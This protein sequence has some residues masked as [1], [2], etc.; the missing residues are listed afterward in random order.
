MAIKTIHGHRHHHGWDSMRAPTAR[1]ASGDSLEFEVLEVTTGQITQNSVASDL[2]I[3]DHRLANPLTGPIA[4]DGAEPGDTLKVTVLGFEPSGW[5]WTGIIPGFGLLAD[6][7]KEP[8]LHHWRYDA[9]SMGPAAFGRIARVPLRPFPSTIGVAPAAPGPHNVML[10]R[11]TAGNINIRNLVAGATLSVPV[12]APG[13]LF[14]VGDIHAAQGDGEVCGAAIESPMKVSLRFDLVKGE[15]LTA[16]SVSTPPLPGSW[17]DR[18]GYEITTG[19]D[20]DLY[21]AARAVVSK[22]IDLLCKRYAMAATDAYMLCSVCGDLRISSAV[23]QP[24]WVVTFHFPR[25]VLS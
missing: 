15:R 17:F 8:I 10:A 20:E 3:I 21:S 7:F 25:A 1:A 24:H 19:L 16:P 23:I 18:D 9:T 2:L 5:G 13:A 22:M 4:I 11:S 14:S 12:E 6:Q